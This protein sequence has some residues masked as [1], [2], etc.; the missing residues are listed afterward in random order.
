[1]FDKSRG[2]SGFPG[3]QVGKKSHVPGTGSHFSIMPFMRWANVF[4]IT[5]PFIFTEALPEIICF[6]IFAMLVL[7]L[8]ARKYVQGLLLEKNYMKASSCFN[9]YLRGTSSYILILHLG[10]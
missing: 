5:C 4:W 2:S 8:F 6:E 9:T 10:E 7:P 1:M 3:F